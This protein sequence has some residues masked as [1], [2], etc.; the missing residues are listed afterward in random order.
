[1]SSPAFII[2]PSFIISSLGLW[3]PRASFKPFRI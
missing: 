3:T 2:S 1:M